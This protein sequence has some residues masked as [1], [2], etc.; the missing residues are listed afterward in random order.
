MHQ[1]IYGEID[2]IEKQHWWFRG[3]RYLLAKLIRRYLKKLPA[4][5][6]LDIGTAT[7]YNL[8][9]LQQ[10]AKK[11]YTIDPSPLAAQLAKKNSPQS[12]V[13]RAF[14]PEVQL[15]GKFQ[16][17]TLLDSLEHIEDDRGSIAKI[18]ELL[19]HGGIAILMVPAYKFLWS[20]QDR[21]LEHRRR[22]LL[23]RLRQLV[24]KNSALKIEYISYF[25][26]VM[27]LPISGYRLVRK[28][29]NFLPGK[30]DAHIF[31]SSFLDKVFYPIFMAELKLLPWIKYPFGIS[32]VAVLK[33]Q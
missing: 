9:I 30:S 18:E 2:Q 21:V 29:A 23:K 17:I 19:D 22:Y 16:I 8:K 25:N 6:A 20:E 24:E 10:F 13:I 15:D 11:T 5:K 3:R 28:T 32:I 4:E 26:S 12:E 1:E 31:N 33:K 7:G 14:F 27:F